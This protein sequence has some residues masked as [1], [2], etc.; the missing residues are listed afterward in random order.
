MDIRLTNGDAVFIN[1][2]LTLAGIRQS[3]QDVVAQRLT[4]RLRSFLGDW[5]IN[6]TYGMPYFEKVLIKNVSKTTVDN[7]FREQILAESG[8]LEI[9]QFSSTFDASS[10]L[11]SC[12]FTVLTREGSA[13]VTVSV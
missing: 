10:R 7:I 8:V 3:A 12:S 9:Q 2:P 5:F 13:S 1:G 4:I 6:T 11:Y